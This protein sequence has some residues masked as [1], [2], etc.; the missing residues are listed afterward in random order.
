MTIPR[1]ASTNLYYSRLSGLTRTFSLSASLFL[2][3]LIP[4]AQTPPDE[5]VHGTAPPGATSSFEGGVESV[6]SDDVDARRDG[7]RYDLESLRAF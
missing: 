5:H 7:D 2:T 1:K 3:T 4:D 6:G